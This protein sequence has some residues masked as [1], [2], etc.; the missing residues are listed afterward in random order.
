MLKPSRLKPSPDPA[1]SSSAPFSAIM[2]VGALVLPDVIR[3]HDRGVDHAQATRGRERAGARRQPPSN[4]EPIMQVPNR[5]EDGRGIGA[6][7]R[8]K[9]CSSVSHLAGPA[10]FHAAHISPWPGS[11]MISRHLR[12]P[13]DRNAPILLGCRRKLFQEMAGGTVASALL[14]RR[15][16]A[17]CGAADTN[18][19]A[20]AGEGMQRPAARVS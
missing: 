18:R 14:M 20:D 3:R 17:A 4:P 7:R 2:K 19:G 6:R 9:I 8:R 16:A 12:Q 11:P 10:G 5:V 13:I 1:K 15:V